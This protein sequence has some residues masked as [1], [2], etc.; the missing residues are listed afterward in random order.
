MIPPALLL[1]G[2][3]G[4]RELFVLLP[5]LLF[6]VPQLFHG[7]QELVERTLRRPAAGAPPDRL[8]PLPHPVQ[9]GRE[10]LTVT[11]PHTQLPRA[12]AHPRASSSSIKRIAPWDSA[13]RPELSGIQLTRTRT[14]RPRRLVASRVRS[15]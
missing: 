6:G 15:T 5:H 1:H 3:V 12:D 8:D 10:L 9:T 14:G 13:A 4:R 7:G 2:E 11:C